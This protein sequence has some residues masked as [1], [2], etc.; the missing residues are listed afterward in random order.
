V[1]VELSTELTGVE[2]GPGANAEGRHELERS[3]KLTVELEVT[4]GIA[5]EKP[6]AWRNAELDRII[7]DPTSSDTT[8]KLA[9]GARALSPVDIAAEHKGGGRLTVEAKVTAEQGRKIAD[10]QLD[11]PNP[12]DPR[13]MDKGT[14]VLIKG[15]ALEQTSLDVG[16]RIFRAESQISNLDGYG[17][18]V[19]KLEG[20]K[21]RVTTGPVETLENE[22]F[23]GMGTSEVRAGVNRQTKLETTNMQTAEFDLGKPEGEQ[24]YRQFLHTMSLPAATT[25]GVRTGRIESTTV[26]DQ[27]AA[28]LKLGDLGGQWEMSKTSAEQRSVVWSDGT[29]DQSIF[30]RSNDR[31]LTIERKLDASGNADPDQTRFSLASANAHPDFAANAYQAFNPGNTRPRIDG[32]Q[33]VQLHLSSDQLMEIRDRAR[34]YMDALRPTSSPIALLAEARNADEVARWIARHDDN[35]GKLLAL[36]I[37]TPGMPPCPAR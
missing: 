31:S 37:E 28:E 10:G 34:H 12:F 14:A 3:Q 16:Y 18:G 21:V 23:L 33:D 13:S 1:G 26:G 5:A 17:I 27:L 36:R 32:H 30:L 9:R 2:T 7:A 19:E 4:G 29:R 22:S 15:Q 25:A 8:R 24:A 20:N 35:F 11:V 6:Q